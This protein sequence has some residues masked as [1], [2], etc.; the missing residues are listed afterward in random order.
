MTSTSVYA[1]IP[2]QEIQVS[3]GQEGGYKVRFRGF[4]EYV[5]TVCT[6]YDMLM[7]LSATIWNPTEEAGSKM[8]DMEPGGWVSAMSAAKADSAGSLH[9]RRARIC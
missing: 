3:D 2:S 9:L 8:G 6:L 7:A 5:A 4:E 1:K